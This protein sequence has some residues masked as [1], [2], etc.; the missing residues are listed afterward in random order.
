MKIRTRL[1]AIAIGVAVLLG[2]GAATQAEADTVST[3]GGTSSKNACV[4]V[5]SAKVAV[6]LDR[7]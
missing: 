1:A 4:V 6:C 5:P 2:L 7:F 3:V